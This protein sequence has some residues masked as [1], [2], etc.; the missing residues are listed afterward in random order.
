MFSLIF[1]CGLITSVVSAPFNNDTLHDGDEP[2]IN[3]TLSTLASTKIPV[4]KDCV[5][6]MKEN[7]ISQIVELFNSNLVNVVV[8]HISFSNSSHEGQLFSDFN[9]S[10]SNPIGREILYALERREF[11]YF[12]WTLKAGI[13]NFKLIVKG[14]QNDC[15]KTGKNGTDFVLESTQHIVGRINLATNYQVCSFFK[16]TSSGKI[17]QTCC[18]MMKPYLATKFNYKCLKVNSFLFIS[19]FI[20]WEVI[21]RIMF[22]FSMYYLMCLLLVFVSR[23]EFNLKYPEFY[24]LEESLMS[25]S[26]ILLKVIWDENGQV[27]SFIRCFVLIGVFS[28]LW[29]WYIKVQ[30]YTSY[31]NIIVVFGG[32]SFLVSNLFRSRSAKLSIFLNSIKWGRYCLRMYQ[33]F[34]YNSDTIWEKGKQGDFE[35]LVKII[36]LPFNPNFWRNVTEL[37]YQICTGFARWATGRFR[38]RILRTLVLCVYCVVA[39]LICFVFTCILF[40]FLILMS[41]TCFYIAL[42]LFTRVFIFDSDNNCF[43]Y[44]LS[45]FHAIGLHMSIFISVMVIAFSIMSFL[46]GLFLNLIYFIPY[47]AFFSVLTFYCCTYWKAME[48]KYFVLKRL[49]YKACQKTQNDNDRCIPNKHLQLNE[50]VLPVVSK[51][52]YDKIRKELLPYETNLFYFGLKMFWSIAFSLGIFALINMLNEFGITGV[53]QVVT[54]ASLGV[55]PHI[56]NMVGLKTSEERKKAKNE[57]LKL[58]VKYMVEKLILKDS[59]LAQAVLITEQN[60]DKRP[61]KISFVSCLKKMLN[62][63]VRCNNDAENDECMTQIWVAQASDENAQNSEK[64]LTRPEHVRSD[65]SA[66]GNDEL[67]QAVLTQEKSNTTIDESIQDESILFRPVPGIDRSTKLSSSGWFNFL[68]AKGQLRDCNKSVT[69]KLNYRRHSSTWSSRRLSKNASDSH[70]MTHVWSRSTVTT[71]GSVRD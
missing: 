30:T 5:L 24:K 66:S 35:I 4:S 8:I 34:F 11:R 63:I 20:L 31:L 18:Q 54:T 10:L 1:Y 71:E 48:E 23:T 9:V 67:A 38:N 40:C 70:L 46:L 16:E 6:E 64:L 7:E 52:L 41:I 17:N 61:Y 56:L 21:F 3:T 12:P 39:V 57:K 45:L 32:L 19:E 44:V 13:R 69:A 36:I 49:I 37:L 51:G 65:L 28:C 68:S 59:K 22:L 62:F 14:S 53:I 33:F 47:L 43:G 26:S 58:N 60:D 29:Y 42:V 2:D 50:E 55:M 15:T 25:P 27:V